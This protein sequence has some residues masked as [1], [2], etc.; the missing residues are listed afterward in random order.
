MLTEGVNIGITEPEKDSVSTG[1]IR[2]AGRCT[3][4]LKVAISGDLKDALQIDCIKGIFSAPVTL[5]ATDGAKNIRVSQ[6]DNE[7]NTAADSRNFIRDTIAPALQLLTPASSPVSVGSSVIVQGLCESGIDVKVSGLATAYSLPCAN[8]TFA[9]TLPLTSQDGNL[10]LDLTQADAAGNQ[11]KLSLHLM[12]DT[13]API[14]KISSPAPNAAVGSVA[15][16]IG[17]C[18]SGLSVELSGSGLSSSVS[19]PCSNGTYNIQAIFTSGLGSKSITATQTDPSGN[20]GSATRAFNRTVNG[21]AIAISSPAN[22]TFFRDTLVVRGSCQ[23][24]LAIQLSGSGWQSPASTT[25]NS[26]SFQVTVTFTSGDGGKTLI[27]SQTDSQNVTGATSATYIRD[28]T[29]PATTIASPTAG[30]ASQ[31]GVK[32]VGACE[33]N[34]NVV[35]SG[36]GVSSSSTVACANGTYSAPIT[37]S[38]GDGSKAITVSQTDAAGNSTSVSRSFTRDTVAPSVSISSPAANTS[39]P[40]GLTLSGTCET[41]LNVVVGGAGVSAPV[42]Q[43]C[44]KGAFSADI[45]FTAVDGVKTVQVSQTDPAG[46]TGV[47]TRDFRRAADIPSLDGAQLYTQNCSICHGPL[48]SSAKRGRTAS[49]ITGAIGSISQMASL[50]NLT[51]SQITAIAEAL[52]IAPTPTPAP[53]L[54]GSND[55]QLTLGNRYYMESLYKELFVATTNQT[56]ED[57]TINNIIKSLV[58]NKTV[59]MGGPCVAHDNACPSAEIAVSALSL[60]MPSGGSMRKGYTTRA[61]EQILEVDK[62]V[63][64]FLGKSALSESSPVNSSNIGLALALMFPGR[65]FPS[66]VIN[67]A[68]DLGTQAKNKGYS[69][70]DTWR[71]VILPFCI[72]STMDML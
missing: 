42:T 65:T 17:T 55:Y 39:A 63:R 19:G 10:T 31:T 43:S 23:T 15:A 71:F 72:S 18:E 46:N 29:A 7:G 2:L 61:C 21:P 33:T 9:N 41:G 38:T 1:E 30:S 45:V 3:S 37:F 6:K 40:T 22:N 49:Q 24:G 8:G 27:L 26:G 68:L 69:G 34:L 50:S 47:S 70:L 62:S 16:V 51:A 67:S 20:Q 5:S 13:V 28:T 48:D 59:A 53:S 60:A 54:P 36:S 14:V 25:C 44:T 32:L 57:T 12:K 11:T 4:G 58:T 35:I 64:N 52:S 66:D 56:Q